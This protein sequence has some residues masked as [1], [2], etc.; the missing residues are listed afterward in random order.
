MQR[1]HKLPAAF[2]RFRKVGGA[3][4]FAVFEDAGGTEDEAIAAIGVALSKARTFNAE[5]LRTLGGSLI[6]ERAFLGDWCD[7]DS[8]ELIQV[9]FWRTESGEELHDPVLKRLDGIR[10]NAGTSR[11]P[12][13][14]EGGDFAYAFTS[15]PYSLR[16]RPSEVQQLFDAIRAFILPPGLEHAIRDWSDPR[17]PEVSRYFDAGADWWGMFLFTI[18]VPELRRLTVASASTTD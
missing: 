5:R 18:H 9:G 16:A 11:I 1:V 4:E 3:V 7:P 2:R 14:G 17:L 13:P 6:G 8:G 12:E 15:P 10:I